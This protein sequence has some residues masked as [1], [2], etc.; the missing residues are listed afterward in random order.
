VVDR[1]KDHHAMGLCRSKPV[2]VQKK[3]EKYV[4]GEVKMQE[5]VVF[6]TAMGLR[7]SDIDQMYACFNILDTDDDGHLTLDEFLVTVGAD[8]TDFALEIFRIFD[9]DRDNKIDFF[10]FVS[11][12]V[13]VC[14]SDHKALAQF[15]FRLIDGDSSGSLDHNEVEKIFSVIYGHHVNENDGFGVGWR[16]NIKYD[17]QQTSVAAVLEVVDRNG[18]GRLS[19]DEFVASCGKF[20]RAIEPAFSLQLRLKKKILGAAFWDKRAAGFRSRF[21]SLLE[22]HPT[23][24]PGD[25]WGPFAR[26]G[27]SEEA[28]GGKVKG[29]RRTIKRNGSNQ[30]RVTPKRGDSRS[31]EVD[32]E[33][34]RRKSNSHIPPVAIR[35][36]AK[37]RR[38]VH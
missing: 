21:D 14:C 36:Q 3:A 32:S 24:E 1:N 27:V 8:P 34:E 20:P 10:E 2:D 18:D 23:S 17:E 19:V 37:Q 38:S 9:F 4:L 26:F 35:S 16:H 7:W 30:F 5:L 13:R 22:K 28:E 29:K 31:F 11:S 33:K 15:A 12:C 25:W 6:M